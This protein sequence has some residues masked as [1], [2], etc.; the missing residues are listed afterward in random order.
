M[1]SILIYSRLCKSYEKNLS[2]ATYCTVG[3]EN[4]PDSGDGGIN[5]QL[6]REVDMRQSYLVFVRGL[7][8]GAVLGCSIPGGGSCNCYFMYTFFNSFF[9]VSIHVWFM[10]KLCIL[11][12]KAAKSH[13]S[14]AFGSC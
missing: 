8:K 5:R 4:L 6:Y 3:S 7:Y 12:R 2:I 1:E 11:R 14:D 13:G 9:L 10:G